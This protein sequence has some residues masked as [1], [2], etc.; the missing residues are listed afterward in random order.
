MNSDPSLMMTYNRMLSS[1]RQIVENNF[2]RSLLLFKIMASEF[3]SDLTLYDRIIKVTTALTNF[4]IHLHPMRKFPFFLFFKSHNR[5]LKLEKGKCLIKR[6]PIPRSC[7]KTFGDLFDDSSENFF[8]EDYFAKILNKSINI[9]GKNPIIPD[10][11]FELYDDFSPDIQKDNIS[12]EDIISK[13]MIDKS[14]KMMKS[15]E[16]FKKLIDEKDEIKDYSEFETFFGNWSIE[17]LKENDCNVNLNNKKG[18]KRAESILKE[19]KYTEYKEDPNSNPQTIQKNNTFHTF[20]GF[21]QSA[22]DDDY[23]Y[24]FHNEQIFEDYQNTNTNNNSNN[25]NVNPNSLVLHQQKDLQ[26]NKIEKCVPNNLEK[27]GNLNIQIGNST[28]SL[29]HI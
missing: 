20:I 15:S 11:E 21:D 28:L 17:K 13:E 7:S 8:L 18:I 16:V 22:M 5:V 2:G 9:P 27:S 1:V 29:I 25:H 6:I 24:L 23:D 10:W 26:I 4:H 3:T 14:V 12:I 19:T